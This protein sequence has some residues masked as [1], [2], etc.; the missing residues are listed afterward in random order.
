MTDKQQL[1]RELANAERMI[2]FWA[3]RIDRLGAWIH[4]CGE[5]NYEGEAAEN[6]ANFTQW[7]EAWQRSISDRNELKTRLKEM[8]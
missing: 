3:T 7:N 6:E 5:D 4:E 2:D 1:R 8:N